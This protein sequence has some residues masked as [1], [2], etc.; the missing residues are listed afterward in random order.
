[1]T[2]RTYRTTSGK[3]LT[4]E[5]IEAIA[6]RDDRHSLGTAAEFFPCTTPALRPGQLIRDVIGRRSPVGCCPGMQC[7]DQ[8]VRVVPLRLGQT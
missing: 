1:M 4:H 3:N 7:D 2:G 8:L 5:D 6:D